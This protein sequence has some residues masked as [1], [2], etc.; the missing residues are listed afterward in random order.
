MKKELIVN[1]QGTFVKLDPANFYSGKVPAAVKALFAQP[2]KISSRR[3]K[4]NKQ[5]GYLPARI[6]NDLLEDYNN[7]IDPSA[8]VAEGAQVVGEGIRIGAGAIIAEGVDLDGFV[9]VAGGTYIGPG[10]TIHKCAV[11]AA[12][13]FIGAENDIF[14]NT[15]SFYTPGPNLIIG[16]K[17]KI[18]G[19]VYLG[20]N[21][22]VG[23]QND[24][25]EG[26]ALEKGA[27]IGDMNMIAARS[28][29]GAH[30]T[31][32]NNC[33]LGKLCLI[34]NE[35]R[36]GNR[37]HLGKFT[38]TGVKCKFADRVAI[39]VAGAI[40]DLVT[41]GADAY[42][43]SNVS[44]GLQAKIKPGAFIDDSG[45]MG[46]NSMLGEKARLGHRAA[47]HANARVPAN[48]KI[49]AHDRVSEARGK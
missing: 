48:K 31:I 3:I 12:R 32:G 28:E 29:L 11:L 27:R 38:Q 37:V 10:T 13:T 16:N 45:R 21:V 34:G 46:H 4:L 41:I 26:V 5:G 40:D 24:I 20:E 8:I 17:N 7:E 47:V 44:V 42:L 18:A 39:D 43:A 23:N 49:S 30:V 22:V 15:G 9:V 25:A 19:Q 6:Q 36:L 1:K 2:L 14:S 33:A 35:T